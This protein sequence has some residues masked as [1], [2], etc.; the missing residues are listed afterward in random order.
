VVG[1]LREALVAAA[2]AGGG[3]MGAELAMRNLIGSAE[4]EALL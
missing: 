2:V 1:P 3:R 4:L